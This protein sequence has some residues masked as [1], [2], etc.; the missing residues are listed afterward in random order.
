MK[1]AESRPLPS[2]C[3]LLGKPKKAKKA[4]AEE[5]DTKGSFTLIAT[6]SSIST[7]STLHHIISRD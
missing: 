7:I 4:S 1:F 3:Y 2:A 6:D 5:S